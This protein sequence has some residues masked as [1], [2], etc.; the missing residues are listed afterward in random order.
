MLY[1]LDRD[2]YQTKGYNTVVSMGGENI[3]QEGVYIRTTYQKVY[4][5]QEYRYDP[6]SYFDDILLTKHLHQRVEKNTNEHPIGAVFN[7]LIYKD[8]EFVEDY[9]SYALLNTQTK[10]KRQ[11]LFDTE[12][13]FVLCLRRSLMGMLAFNA[14]AKYEFD[15]F[16]FVNTVYQS[17]RKKE[18]NEKYILDKLQSVML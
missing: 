7:I 17:Y 14:F 4:A 16:D 18:P 12:V 15:I 5:P 13:S 3:G 2:G 6:R 11:D 8:G 9:P 10:N 1:K